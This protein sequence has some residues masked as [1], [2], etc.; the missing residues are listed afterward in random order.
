MAGKALQEYARIWEQPGWLCRKVQEGDPD[1]PPGH[2]KDKLQHGIVGKHRSYWIA[3]SALPNRG[4]EQDLLCQS[5]PTMF[6]RQSESAANQA[7]GQVE[8][9]ESELEADGFR[10]EAAPALEK[11]R[12]R[13]QSSQQR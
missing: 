12:F 11:W 1:R 13:P 3:W 9:L 5:P 7:V 8:Y 6:A 4:G 10:V 2:G